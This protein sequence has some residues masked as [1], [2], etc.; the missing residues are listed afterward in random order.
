M[1]G[2]SK[3]TH[4]QRMLRHLPSPSCRCVVLRIGISLRM[5]C[6]LIACLPVSPACS[7]ENPPRSFTLSQRKFV[8]DV[9]PILVAR[10]AFYACHG[11]PARP[12]AVFGPNRLR[13]A[14]PEEAREQPLT[15]EEHLANFIA[16]SSFS[17]FDSGYPDPL[18]LAKTIEKRASGAFHRGADLYGGGNVYADPMVS[19]AVIIREWLN[20]NDGVVGNPQEVPGCEP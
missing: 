6:L 13:L 20:G 19:E 11:N 1:R 5:V 17:A 18:L 8:C 12:F 3:R 4:L 16:A 9:E 7:V 15:R 2:N 14:V 10:C